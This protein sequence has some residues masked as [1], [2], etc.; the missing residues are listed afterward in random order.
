MPSDLIHVI[1]LGAGVQS[2]TMAL[3]AAHGEIEPMPT[4]AIF[5]DTQWEPKAVYEWLDWLEQQLPFP[6]HRVSEGN[7]WSDSLQRRTSGKSG[8]NYVRG[9]VPFWIRNPD[10][11]R[12]ATIR[13]C[14]RDYKLTP[15]F[16]KVKSLCGIAG[17]LPEHPV[18]TMWIG[19]STDEAIRMKPSSFGW[20]HNRWPLIERGMTRADCLEWMRRHQY[21]QPPRSACVFC[22]YRSGA[23]W[24]RMKDEQPH[25]FERAVAYE[26][27]LR[28]VMAEHDDVIRGEPYLWDGLEPLGEAI[29][30]DKSQLDLFGEEC[31]GMCGV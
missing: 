7:L 8:R 31:A 19:I 10:G 22:P 13:K 26:H 25:E 9:L 6:V 16:R 29:F 23:E 18:T 3:M 4:C 20:M 14:T 12:G 2:S 30:S 5:A 17:R 28:A 1:S 11:S 21:P 24:Q 15:I 27:E